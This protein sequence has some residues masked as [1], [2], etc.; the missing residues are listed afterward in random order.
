MHELAIIENML[1]VID[2]QMKE[3]NIKHLNK[4]KIVVGELSG[5]VPDVLQFCWQVST[6]GSDL[7]LT[8]LELEQ[9]P[10]IAICNCCNKE[11]SLKETPACPRCGGGVKEIISGK[12]LYID[13]IEGE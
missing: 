13:Y 7:E 5:V 8:V 11:Y 12:E 4:V 6:E 3:H 1:H 10:A 2:S 9:K